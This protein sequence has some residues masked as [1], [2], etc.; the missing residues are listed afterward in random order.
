MKISRREFTWIAGGAVALGAFSGS[1]GGRNAAALPDSSNDVASLSLAAAGAKLRA[2]QLSSVDLTR[3]CLEHIDVYNRQLN[4]FITVAKSEALA[5]AEQADGEIKAGRYRGLLHGI[6]FAAKDNID[7]SAIRTTG[8]SALFEDRVPAEDAPVIVRLK[9]AGAVLIGKTN[10]QEFALG[11][12]NT[13]YW[14]PVRNPW[15]LQHYSGGSSSGSGAAVTAHMCYG[16]LGTDTGG[17]VRIPASYCGIVGLKATYGLVPDRGIIP[18]ILSLDHCGL[19]TRTVEDSA[20]MLNSVAGYDRLDITSVDHPKEDYVAGMRQPIK[21]FRL[22][23]PLGHFDRLQPDVEK[24]VREAIALLA[25]VTSG[26]KDVTLPPVGIAGNLGPEILAW[27]EEY[28]KTQSGKYMAQVRRSLAGAEAGNARAVDYIRA[29]WAL[30]ELRRTVDDSFT[31]F[32]LVVLPTTRIVAQTVEE[33]LKRDADTEPQ[34]PVTDYPDCVYF[35]IYGLPAISVPCGFSETGMPI[36][37]TIAGPHFSESRVLALANAYEA[38]TQ[39]HTRQPPL[40]PDTP[41]PGLSH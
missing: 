7:S 35:N 27:H 6:P 17:S 30:E 13:S 22:G 20:I 9:Q 23:M 33:L 11:A 8:G 24:A 28:F 36:G 19:L 3:A 15:N 34:D 5:A 12:S 32:D 25:G 2:R 10:L 41:V 29:R 1:G 38:A 21:G 40:A 16:A 31:D 37:L 4:A 14:G 39:W 18:G 26:V